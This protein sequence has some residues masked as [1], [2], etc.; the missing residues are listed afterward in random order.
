MAYQQ[1][2]HAE[3]AD[4]KS[5]PEVGGARAVTCSRAHVRSRERGAVLRAP[6]HQ[7]RPG[8]QEVPFFFVVAACERALAALRFDVFDVRPSR[9]VDDAFVAALFDVFFVVLRYDNVLPAALFDLAPVDLLV[10]VFEA[11]FAALDPVFLVA[12]GEPVG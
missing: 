12:I 1:R 9:S 4:Q 6:L 11:L 8:A 7:L 5:K 3:V 10:S 2:D